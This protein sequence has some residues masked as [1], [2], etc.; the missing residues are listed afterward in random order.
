ME[1]AEMLSKS[2]LGKI[3]MLEHEMTPDEFIEHTKKVLNLS[4]CALRIR[5]RRDP[6]GRAV[7]GFRREFIGLA[8]IRNADVF[9]T[10]EIG[11]HGLYCLRKKTGCGC[12]TRVISEPRSRW[13][14]FA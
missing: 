9:V 5:L 6:Q 13:S 11:I 7:Y 12:L 14:I 1:Q 4:I 8:K 2:G 10:G 3:G